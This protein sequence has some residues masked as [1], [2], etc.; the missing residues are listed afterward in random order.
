MAVESIEAVTARL[1][2]DHPVGRIAGNLREVVYGGNDGIVTTFAVVA[3]F[4]GAAM[5]GDTALVGAVAVLLFGLANLFSDAAAMGLGAF[6][7]ARSQRD[8]YFAV[9]AAELAEIRANPEAER[10]EIRDLLRARGVSAA[11][12]AQFADLY[13]R[14]PEL[15]AD[16]MMR[17]EM[18]MADPSDEVPSVTA[19]TTFTSFILFGSI[20]LIPYFLLPPTD[21]TFFLSVFATFAALA[22]LGLVRWRVTTE[23][24]ARAV[25]ETVAVGGVCAIIAYAVGVMFRI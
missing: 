10:A 11:D 8:V 3:G 17:H 18:G 14:H 1:R 20:P 13:I 22:L 9:R 21:R 15:A 5:G 7:S 19:L 24:A 25:G 2:A 6:L 16:F 4:A 23:N 12:A